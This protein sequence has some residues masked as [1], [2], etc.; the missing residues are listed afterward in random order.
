[1]FALT[2][3]AYALILMSLVHGR[4]AAEL[5]AIATVDTLTGVRTRRSFIDKARRV[6]DAAAAGR[7]TNRATEEPASGA[8]AALMMLDIDHF[9]R[10][11]DR[12]GHAAGDRVL[13]RFAEELRA[14][15]P[16]GAVVGRYGGEE[17]CMLLPGASLA[18]GAALAQV[19]C[20]RVGSAS[21]SQGDPARVATVSIGVAGASDGQ[22]LE[23]LLLA[24]DRRL[25]LAK[26]WGRN[27]VV[28][29]DRPVPSLDSPRRERSH[30]KLVPV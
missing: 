30:V 14:V 18:E 1:M 21:F 6:L 7:A 15:M 3:I 28:A 27:Q 20:N 24:A 19:I 26:D 2:P 29:T 9:K 12:H 5:W 23:E 13:V 22:T 10:I 17:F 11:N 25:Y 8:Q 16:P 4:V